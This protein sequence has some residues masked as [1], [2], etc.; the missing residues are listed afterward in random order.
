M[1]GDV[2]RELRQSLTD[3]VSTVERD[4]AESFKRWPDIPAVAKVTL[5]K[6]A[7]AR[8][9]RPMSLFSDRTCPIIGIDELGEL[10]TAVEPRGLQQL[11][12]RI[13][14]DITLVGEA[15]ISTI[16]TIAAYKVEEDE[17]ASLVKKV[18]DGLEK[19]KVRLFRHKNPG[20]DH[21]L[22]RGLLE[23]LSELKLPEPELLNYGK[24]LRIMRVT[25][26]RPDHVLELASYVGT[27]N[28][29]EFPALVPSSPPVMTSRS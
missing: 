20:S 24:Q 16:A 17:I 14:T 13:L 12:S 28:V 3:Q 8:S 9:H 29:S 2:T 21:V 23:L 27:Q 11:K 26:I 6:E 18:Q 19:V 4:F 7:L 25:G 5:K 10:L 1:F 22:L 15:N